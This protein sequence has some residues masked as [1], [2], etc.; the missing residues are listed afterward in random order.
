MR[1]LL[2]TLLSA[3]ATIALALAVTRPHAVIVEARAQAAPNSRPL[4]RLIAAYERIRDNYV[5]ELDQSELVDAAIKGMIGM[6]NSHSNYFSQENFGDMQISHRPSAGLGIEAMME[7]GLVK[8]IAPLDDTSAAKTGVTTNDVI[9]HIDDVPVQGLNLHQAFEK[10]RGPANTTVRLKIMRRGHDKPIELSV[11]RETF[12]S[13]L[14]RMRREGED[15]D[16]I[17]I[18]SINEGTLAGLR[19][20]IGELL[21]SNSG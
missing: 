3:V 14:V 12:R 5:D 10:M 17:R 16:Y 20:A 11:V 9:T 4:D 2:L 21:E 13:R 18:P 6:L 19:K 15:I 7:N 1:K 8:V